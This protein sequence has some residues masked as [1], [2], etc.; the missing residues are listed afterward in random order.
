MN[1]LD[2]NDNE[3]EVPELNIEKL[4]GIFTRQS[5]LHKKYGPIETRNGIG[6][7]IVEGTPFD[8]DNPKWQYVIKDYAWRVAEELT[9]ALEAYQERNEP[10]TVE[11]LI[12]ALHFYTELLLI[13][14]YDQHDIWER[15]LEASESNILYPI[16]HI[17][18]ACNLLKNKP[19]K[20]THVPTDKARFKV[21]LI[22]GYICLL[23][24]IMTDHLA[25]LDD[26]YRVYFKKSLVNS[27]RIRSNY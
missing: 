12:D 9:E 2:V 1:I 7:A 3:I 22:G 13:C 19:W 8:L 6:L 11:E 18:L 5:E 4:K 14:G 20:N 27:F 15:F 25:S 21:H 16:Y 17:G 10:H 26:V 24:L 23:Q